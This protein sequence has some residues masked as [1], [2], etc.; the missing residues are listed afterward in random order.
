MPDIP[1]DV[2][3][4]YQLYF[5]GGDEL[6]AATL[7]N[8]LLNTVALTEEANKEIGIGQSLEI[9]VKSTVKEVLS[10]I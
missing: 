4:E 7:G 5:G 6:D 1:D 9:K 3:T 8:V 2:T 10:L